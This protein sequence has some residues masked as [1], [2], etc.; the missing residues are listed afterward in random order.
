MRALP[1]ELVALAAMTSPAAASA[2]DPHRALRRILAKARRLEDAADDDQQAQAQNGGG[3]S[4]FDFA[5]TAHSL[6]YH[7]CASVRQFDDD[8][9]ASGASSGVF[10][11]KHFAVVRLCPSDTCSERS[12]YASY[13][14]NDG[15]FDRIRYSGANGYGCQSNYGQYI[16]ELGD[17]LEIMVRV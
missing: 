2:G 14:S 15:I 6:A 10:A 12:A 1:L 3:G 9:A 16:L 8:L 17:Y 5:P 4:Q 11:T 7:R 13:Y